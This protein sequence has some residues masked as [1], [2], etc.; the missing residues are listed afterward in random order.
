MTASGR[1]TKNRN[2]MPLLWGS[3]WPRARGRKTLVVGLVAKPAVAGNHYCAALLGFSR[4][5]QIENAIQPI[6][7][8]LKA[9]S[10]RQIDH[11]IAIGVHDV[12]RGD[13]VG[14]PEED[15]AVAVSVRRGR[16]MQLDRFAVEEQLVAA[17]DVCLGRPGFGRIIFHA[18]GHRIAG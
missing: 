1:R 2:F 16:M 4:D 9:P 13:H 3:G 14:T 5:G 18:R 8:S 15:Y 12:A 10:P 17:A 6:Y 11:R 7:N